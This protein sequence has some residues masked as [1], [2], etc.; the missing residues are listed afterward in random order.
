MDWS[1]CPGC[2]VAIG[3]FHTEGCDWE[4]CPLCHKQSLACECDIPTLLDVTLAEART[5]E[6]CGLNDEQAERWDAIV[7]KKGLIRWG[8]EERLKD[9]F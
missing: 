4:E 6:E 7:Q 5:I 2:R 8:S 3:T 9:L 1:T